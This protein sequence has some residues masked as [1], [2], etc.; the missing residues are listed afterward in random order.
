MLILAPIAAPHLR[1]DGPHAVLPQA[2][3]L[4]QEGVQDVWILGRRPDVQRLAARLVV[5]ATTPRASM[6]LGASRWFTIHWAIITPA[7]ST[8][9]SS[10]SPWRPIQGTARQRAEGDV[11]RED[12]LQYRRPAD[13][14]CLWIDRRRQGLVVDLD[15]VGRVARH[16]AVAGHHHRDRIAGKADGVDRHRAVLGRREWRPDRHRRQ[17]LGDVRED[18]LHPVHRFGGA[19]IDGPDPAV[20]DIAA[21]ERE[22]LHAGDLY[23]VAVGTAS[24]DQAWV[25]ATLDALAD[26]LRQDGRYDQGLSAVRV[27]RVAAV[28][29]GV[30]QPVVRMASA[31]NRQRSPRTRRGQRHVRLS[32]ARGTPRR[33]QPRSRTARDRD[34]LRVSDVQASTQHAMRQADDSEHVVLSVVSSETAFRQFTDKLTLTRLQVFPAEDTQ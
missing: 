34:Q 13:H 15:G 22:V 2:E 6:D 18:R 28:H 29:R 7:A 24:L 21:L 8:A 12:G 19:D 26:E 10:M 25:L 23:V 11:V 1:G 5:R 14:C 9:V 4:R 31:G 17:E 27:V 16:V 3:R 32:S 30:R 20:R 33:C